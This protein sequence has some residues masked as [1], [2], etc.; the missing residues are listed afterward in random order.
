MSDLLPEQ[1]R[2][3]KASAIVTDSSEADNESQ[4]YY[5][6]PESARVSSSHLSA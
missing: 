3:R 6:A 5:L 1:I 4:H 2:A